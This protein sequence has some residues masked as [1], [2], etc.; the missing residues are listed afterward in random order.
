VGAAAAAADE[1]PLEIQWDVD[2]VAVAPSADDTPAIDWGVANEE[3]VGGND[4]AATWAIEVA[5]AGQ[6][7]TGTALDDDRVRSLLLTDL[8][9]V[10]CVTLSVLRRCS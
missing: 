6:G 1:G 5:D 4:A 10:H 3:A 7:G 8:R 2:D 9:E